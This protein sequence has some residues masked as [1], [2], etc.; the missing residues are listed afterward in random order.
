MASTSR[1]RQVAY[2]IL[3]DRSEAEDGAA[4]A[5]TRA[6]VTWRKV[7]APAYRDAWVLRVTANVAIDWRRR[8]RVGVDMDPTVEGMEEATVV[9]LALAAALAAAH[10]DHGPAPAPRCARPHR[11][12]RGYSRRTEFD[13]KEQRTGA[14]H[15]CQFKDVNIS[16]VGACVVIP[17]R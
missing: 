10:G 16:T 4:E 1:A 17:H 5:F 13:L 8:R 12:H 6:L 7:S 11:P 9:R 15:R 14:F 3:G 2:R